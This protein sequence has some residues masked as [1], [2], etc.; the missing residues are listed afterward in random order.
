MTPGSFILSLCHTRAQ[1][2]HTPMCTRIKCSSVICL[3]P[4]CFP[5]PLLAGV[6]HASIAG[7]LHGSIAGIFHGRTST[8]CSKSPHLSFTHLDLQS[9]FLLEEREAENNWHAVPI[10]LHELLKRLRNFHGHP[11]CFWFLLPPWKHVRIGLILENVVLQY[12]L[13]LVSESRCPFSASNH[14]RMKG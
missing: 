3:L 8:L 6:F 5:S 13:D 2:G 4:L 1:P 11:K 14:Y 10:C 7:V 12:F 9:H